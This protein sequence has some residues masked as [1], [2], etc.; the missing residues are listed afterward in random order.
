MLTTTQK[1]HSWTFFLSFCEAFRAD[2]AQKTRVE[3]DAKNACGI[4]AKS[5]CGYWREKCMQKL[6]REMRAEIGARNACGNWREIT[7]VLQKVTGLVS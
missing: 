7:W 1:L 6:A 4:G 2:L 3:S 5:A